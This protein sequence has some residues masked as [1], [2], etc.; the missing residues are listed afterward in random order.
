MQKFFLTALSFLWVSATFT[1]QG[2]SGSKMEVKSATKK[3]QQV[4][5][6]KPNP[7]VYFDVQIQGEK[8]T[9][10]I[11]ME[12]RADKAPKPVENFRAL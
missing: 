6:V 12:L 3:M 7:V 11:E 9:R 5:K 10:R 8:S 1:A 2:K 4:E